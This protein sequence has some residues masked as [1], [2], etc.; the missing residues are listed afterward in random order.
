MNEEN[1][2]LKLRIYSMHIEGPVRSM[3]L[4]FVQESNWSYMPGEVMN[5]NVSI[6][7]MWKVYEAFLNLTMHAWY[8]VESMQRAVDNPIFKKY[9]LKIKAYYR[10]GKR[11]SHVHN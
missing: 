4:P 1:E 8:N 10:P 11:G 9:N 3:N 5:Q 7:N 2:D 6:K